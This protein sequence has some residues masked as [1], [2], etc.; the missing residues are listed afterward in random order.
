MKEEA[1]LYGGIQW[2]F[3]SVCY[4]TGALRCLWFVLCKKYFIMDTVLMMT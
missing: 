1:L 4:L 2:R 3:F